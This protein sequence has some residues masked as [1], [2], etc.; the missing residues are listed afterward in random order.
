MP[1]IP[2]NPKDVDA[3]FATMQETYGILVDQKEKLGDN[4]QVP[5]GDY[6]LKLV[7]TSLQQREDKKTGEA[8]FGVMRIYTIVQGDFQ[9]VDVIDNISIHYDF[10]LKSLIHWLAFLGKKPP[11]APNFGQKIMKL[12]IELTEE[13]PIHTAN[14]TT[15]KGGFYKIVPKPT[16]IDTENGPELVNLLKYAEEEVES[17]TE[18]VTPPA[19]ETK[20]RKPR[21]SRKKKVAEAEFPG[22]GHGSTGGGGGSGP[23][24]SQE[25][26]AENTGGFDT[27]N[28]PAK[29]QKVE[30]ENS[31][32]ALRLKLIEFTKK[33][34]VKYPDDPT[35][36]EENELTDDKQIDEITEV[37]GT[38]E[39][40]KEDITEED[41]ALFGI[42]GLQNLIPK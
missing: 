10:S 23:W 34:S 22:V 16:E 21:K 9:F 11:V 19:T 31:D 24:S 3:A 18:K 42:V 39:F 27:S 26:K 36:Y 41:K 25:E 2:I 5:D 14:V 15:N 38:Y 17:G 35:I 37:L 40:D 29:E 1:S 4:D 30:E 28:I 32:E 12:C 7:S 8:R 6:I 20:T 13:K 33:K